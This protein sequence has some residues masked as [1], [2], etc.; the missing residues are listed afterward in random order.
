MNARTRRDLLGAVGAASAAGLAGCT[1][2]LLPGGDE[3]ETETVDRTGAETV[4]VA[5]GADGGFSFAPAAVR[6]DVGTTVVWEWTGV[7]GSHNVVDRGGAF[8]SGL[9]T[10][11]GHAFEHEFAEPGTYEYVCTPHQTR[12]MEGVVEVVEE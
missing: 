2:A 1:G 11:E 5:V 3:G 9:A 6:V 4:S 7:G 8:E 10:A 12:D